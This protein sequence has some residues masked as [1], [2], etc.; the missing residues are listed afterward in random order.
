[1]DIQG[2]SIDPNFNIYVSDKGAGRVRVLLPQ[3][4]ES[5]ALVQ[6]FDCPACKYHFP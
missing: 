3:V 4:S 5:G 6:P 1:M 2:I